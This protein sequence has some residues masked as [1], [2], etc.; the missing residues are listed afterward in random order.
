MRLN[1]GLVWNDWLETYL[2]VLGNLV[3]AELQQGGKV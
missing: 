3:K 1:Y 2:K